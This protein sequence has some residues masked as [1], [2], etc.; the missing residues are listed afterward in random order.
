MLGQLIKHEFRATARRMLPALGV[1]A[2]L[3]LLANL[4]FRIL[5]SGFG[6]TPLRI[7]LVLFIIAFFIGMIVAWVMALVMMI[8]RFYRNLLGDEG[9]LMFTLPTNTHALIWSKLIVSTVWFIATAL[10]IFL[11]MMLTGA[12]LAR[13]NGEDLAGIFHSMGEGLEFLRT[14]GVTNGSLILLGLEFV[15]AVVVTSLTTCLQ[16]YA[17]MG[18]GQMSDNHKGLWS[19]LAFVG[20]SFAFQFLGTT[21][22]AGL[23]GTDTMNVVIANLEELMQTAPGIVRAINA[24]IGS[25]MLLEL[26]HGVILYLIT[27]LTLSKKLNLA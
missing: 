16:F 1:L 27:S 21:V 9:Y 18:L 8:S 3:G 12:N 24:G 20:L 6:G 7:L 11:L 13:M 22:F 4:S 14:L 19:V 17:A 5:D 23:T 10:L 2:L 15:A 25:T 26:I